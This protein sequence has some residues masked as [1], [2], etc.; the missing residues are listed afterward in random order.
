VNGGITNIVITTYNCPYKGGE[1]VRNAGPWAVMKIVR[2]GSVAR[3]A[4]DPTGECISGRN[5]SRLRG[6]KGVM[7]E[8]TL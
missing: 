2:G 6:R 7:K 8:I 5:I 4:V 3:K 1:D